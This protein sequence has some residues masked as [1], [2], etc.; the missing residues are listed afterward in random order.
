MTNLLTSSD[1]LSNIE[2]LEGHLQKSVH[3][4]ELEHNNNG[5]NNLIQELQDS[6]SK[7][8]PTL[9]EDNLLKQ[10]LQY[11]SLATSTDSQ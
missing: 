9:T 7:L 5:L 6:I 10:L 1:D 11:S 4:Q 3:L 2:P 8:E